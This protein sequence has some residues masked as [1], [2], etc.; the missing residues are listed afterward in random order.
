[1]EFQILKEKNEIRSEH[2]RTFI[3]GGGGNDTAAKHN[4]S[5]IPSFLLFSQVAAISTRGGK[6]KLRMKKQPLIVSFF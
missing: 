2:E 6:K 5:K 3:G 1:M 4:D